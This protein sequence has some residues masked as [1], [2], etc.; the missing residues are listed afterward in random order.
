MGDPAVTECTLRFRVKEYI[1]VD[2]NDYLVGR[3]SDFQ[4]MFKTECLKVFAQTDPIVTD[5]YW[6]HSQTDIDK[7]AFGYALRDPLVS[8]SMP[9]VTPVLPSGGNNGAFTLQ[10]RC[11]PLVY[12]LRK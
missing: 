6:T 11:G 4:I 1:T 12:N 10:D 7:M 9:L 5:L 3:T 8:F 2:G